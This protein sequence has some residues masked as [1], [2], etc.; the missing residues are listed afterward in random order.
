M[1][2]K[3]PESKTRTPDGR[4]RA[5]LDTNIWRYVVDSGA[6]GA[7]LRAAR[8]GAYS[9]QIA[10]GV[11]YETL[12]L[13]DAPLRATL[14]RLMANQ[15]FQRLMPE[16]Y[17]ESMEILR[18]IERVRPDWLRDN[19]DLRFFNRLRNDWSRKT[20][21]FWVRCERSPLSEARHVTALDR[22]QIED[23][24]AEAAEARKEMAANK[25]WKR[26]PPMDTM[27]TGFIHPVPG[28]RGD[29]VEAWRTDSFL[30]MTYALARPDQAYR[31]WMCPF[32]EFDDGLLRSAAWGEFWL[33]LAN[34]SSLPRQWL[35]WA[36]AFAQRF[37][38]VTAGSPG[39]SQLL[40]YFVET[41]VV[42]TA[43]RALL[44]ILDECRPYAPC[45]LPEGQL[46]PAG[47][48]GVERLLQFLQT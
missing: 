5:L 2:A 8:D 38:K 27:L 7:L 17:S 3:I 23:A 19:P 28:W 6:Q 45:Q 29:M 18:E 36:H 46:V 30:S 40:T 44:D 25:R 37:R 32:I 1:I 24:R 9:V 41:D 31:D 33:Y 39:D 42:I 10:P 48:P 43:D 20:G 12:R 22:G 47:A 35:R 13:K 15:R 14:V 34:K 11:I 21:G 26:I 4:K 16:A